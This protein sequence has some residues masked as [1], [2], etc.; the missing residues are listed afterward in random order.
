[1]AARRCIRLGIWC[2]LG[3]ASELFSAALFADEQKPAGVPEATSKQTAEDLF[4]RRIQ[5]LLKAK[6]LACHGDDAKDI[7]GGFD[8]R[9]RAGTLKG[10]ESGEAAVVPGRPEKS[11]LYVAVTRK[12][13]ALVM[14]PK[15]NDKLSAEEIEWIRQ[16]IAGG[17]PWSEKKGTEGWDSADGVRVAT[18]GGRSEEWTNRRY[19]PEDLWAYQPVRRPP[20]PQVGKAQ[21][22]IQN[23]IDS[24][25]AARLATRGI[26]RFAPP[27]DRRTLIR[28]AT[29]DLTGLPPSPEDVEAFVRDSAVN[30][31]ERL[32]ERLLASPHY[33][34]QMARHWLDVVRYAD[35]SGFSNDFERPNAWRYRDYVVRSFNRDKPFDRF[36]VE[37]IAGDELNPHDPEKLIAAGFLRMGPWEHTAMTVAAVTRQQYL[38][39]ITHN[40]GVAFLGQALRCAQCH[41]HKFDPIPTQDYYRMQAVFATTHFAERDVPF[42]PEENVAGFA[43]GRIASER[44]LLQAKDVL[45]V[46]KSKNDAAV[47]E[48]VKERGAARFDDLPNDDRKRRDTLGLTKAELSIKKVYEKRVQYF[49]RELLRYEPLAFSVYSGPSNNYQSPR[50]TNPIPRTA[51]SEAI[52]VVHVLLRGSLESPAEAVSPGVLS[53]M[54]RTEQANEPADV[55][56]L[57]AE[58]SGR[59][60]A[61]ARWIASPDNAFTARVIVN[62][63]WQWHFGT[64][65]ARTPNNFGKMGA[66]P[67]H[68][69][70]LDWLAA[71]FI[72]QGWSV[73]KLHALIMASATYRQSGEHPEFDKLRKIDSR[74]ELLAYF[75]SRRLAAEELR[76]GLL[77]ITDELNGEMGGPGMFP[78]IHREVALQP[79]HIMGSVA[80]AYQPSAKPEMRHRR[81]LYAFRIRTLADPLLE[82]FNRPGSEVS[83]ERRDETTVTP[84]AFALF[85]SEFAQDRA[86]A[87]AAALNKRHGSMEAAINEAF[88]R[89]YGRLPAANELQSCREHVARMTDHHRQSPAKK[90]ELPTRVTRHMVEEMTGEDVS[91]EEELADYQSDLKPWDVSAEVRALADL[92]LVLLNSNEF[93]YVR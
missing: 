91:W 25:I 73:K 15:E 66:K 58:V 7:K 68:P 14:P 24:F 88:R 8:L 51:K 74:N 62:R 31:H 50:L 19:R 87:L 59:R 23:P 26:Q 44:R 35:T 84:Q 33:G 79:R 29:F 16:W 43:E 18:N 86:I 17:A 65:L 64:G 92:C 63:V 41:D 52:P 60:L 32:I 28:R 48:Y 22:A 11:P 93:L 90:P 30:A 57:P 75:P 81:T 46:L 42:L 89:A 69:E 78:E 20:I 56:S 45:A 72:D 39:D 6:C 2:V 21:F 77:A 40:V 61:L 10:G 12:D 4:Q 27:A 34:E 85:N 5:P 1:M 71:W 53:A 76:D 13:Q 49:E 36:V 67:S 37:Q 80:P 55:P 3:A 54:S 38:D 83:C 9:T 82:V 47:A 70:L